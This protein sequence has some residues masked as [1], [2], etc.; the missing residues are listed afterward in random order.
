MSGDIQKEKERIIKKI[1]GMLERADIE[2]V[3]LA[4]RFVLKILD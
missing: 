1:I 3:E 4:Y 2:M